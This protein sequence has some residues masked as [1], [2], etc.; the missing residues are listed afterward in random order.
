M[1][2]EAHQRAYDLECEHREQLDHLAAAL[3]QEETLD[4]R[5]VMS[6][7]AVTTR[8]ALPN[9]HTRVKRLSHWRTIL[10]TGWRLESKPY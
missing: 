4:A 2:Q 5:R 10:I 6:I 8:Y 7:L 9:L 3:L 1:L